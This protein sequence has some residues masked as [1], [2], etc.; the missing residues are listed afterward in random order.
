L[1][2]GSEKGKDIG[3]RDSLHQKIMFGKGLEST[4]LW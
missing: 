1:E 4:R 2:S 3:P